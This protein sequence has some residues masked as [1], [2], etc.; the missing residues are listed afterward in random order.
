VADELDVPLEGADDGDTLHLTFRKPLVVG[1]KTYTEID[2][3][4]PTWGEM[5]AALKQGGIEASTWLA[6]TLGHIPIPA[7]NKLDARDG[8]IIDRF[9]AR[10]S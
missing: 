1:E 4:A 9:F 3:Q 8:A 6:S 5:K 2:C 10:F 7:L